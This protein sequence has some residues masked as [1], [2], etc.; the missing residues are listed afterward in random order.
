MIL[1]LINS[2]RLQDNKKYK[3]QPCC[4]SGVSQ[5]VRRTRYVNKHIPTETLIVQLQMDNNV[6]SE[7]Q[8]S[9][10][11]IVAPLLG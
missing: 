2:L 6:P 10:G 4:I 1:E 7:M 5:Q 8:D 3:N 9:N 11:E